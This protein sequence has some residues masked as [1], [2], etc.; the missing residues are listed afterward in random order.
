[1]KKYM[2]PICMLA[3]AI[4][5]LVIGLLVQFAWQVF[6]CVGAAFG[7]TVGT[8]IQLFFNETLPDAY[9]AKKHRKSD[10]DTS[11]FAEE[12]V[13]KR[14]EK[15][16]GHTFHEKNVEEEE[17]DVANVELTAEEVAAKEDRLRRAAQRK[18]WEEI[19]AKRKLERVSTQ[20]TATPGPQ[21][22]PQ[23]QPQKKVVIVEEDDD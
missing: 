18:Q 11:L 21:P 15:K 16:I 4:I 22:R 19:Q 13:E 17:D 14:E 9:F 7:I 6:A 1:M 10:M 12:E 3:G 5:G 8:V 2:I 20:R 23:P